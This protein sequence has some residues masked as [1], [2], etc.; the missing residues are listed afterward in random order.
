MSPSEIVDT[1]LR[2]IAS[3]DRWLT[4]RY[5]AKFHRKVLENLIEQELERRRQG[6]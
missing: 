5:F 4:F 1:W 3:P 2:N 6:A